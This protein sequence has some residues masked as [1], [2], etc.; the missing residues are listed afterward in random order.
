MSINA[1]AINPVV[2]PPE[3]QARMKELTQVPLLPWP[4]VVLFLCRGRDRY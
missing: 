3:K 1:T 4:S 2:I